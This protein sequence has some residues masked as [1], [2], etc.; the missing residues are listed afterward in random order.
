MLKTLLQNAVSGIP[1]LDK[2]KALEELEHTHKQTRYVPFLM[3]IILTYSY[4]VLRI[5]IPLLAAR[6]SLTICGI[7]AL[8]PM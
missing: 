8:L 2:V 1:D 5:L 4:L 3:P 6:L 7:A